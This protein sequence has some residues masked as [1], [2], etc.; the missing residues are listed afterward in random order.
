MLNRIIL[1]TGNYL[2]GKNGGIENYTH[3]LAKHLVENKFA[4]EIA[5]LQ[6]Y[7]KQDYFYEGIKV[8]YLGNSISVFENVLRNGQYDICHFH[9]YSAYGGIEVPWFKLAKELCKKVFFTF[10]LPYLTCYKNDFRYKGLED[11]NNFTDP[12]R[13]TPCII[14]DKS[15]FRKSGKSDLLLKM[16]ETV[17]SITGKRKKLKERVIENYRT[18]GQLLKTCDKVFLIAN[19]FYE[20]LE[21]NNYHSDNIVLLSN[22]LQSSIVRNSLP[23]AKIK[24]NR[25][26]FVGRIQHQKGLHLLCHALGKL[27][28][29][30]ITLD[31]YGN[32]VDKLYF[33][34]C[35]KKYGFNYK[36]NIA[37]EE[38]LKLLPLY[39]FLILPSVFTE[40]TPMVIQEA[41]SAHLPVIAST[42]K[43]N[44]DAITDGVNGFLFEYDNADDLAVTIEK[45]YRLKS[46]GWKPQFSYPE[47]P[48]KDIE[49]IVSYYY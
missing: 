7:E 4:V 3:E 26:I 24:K 19:W 16:L 2:P 29:S 46:N 37:R 6:L 32:V 14:A 5:S 38:L 35:F 41:F 18:L 39:E 33:E 36:G 11:C 43:G 42:A 23:D 8:N 40:M 12:E 31:V 13:C 30:G 1:V 10:H 49:E 47:N 21:E 9:E 34:R 17:F 22:G 15:H 28:T 20:L 25:I 48:E 44:K 45:A 27:K